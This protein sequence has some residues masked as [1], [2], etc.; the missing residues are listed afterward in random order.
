MLQFLASRRSV[1]THSQHLL[2]AARRQ[3][4]FQ[5]AQ[6]VSVSVFFFNHIFSIGLRDSPVKLETDFAWTVIDKLNLVP[7][8]TTSIQFVLTVSWLIP[9]SV[10]QQAVVPA[11]E[12]RLLGSE[13]FPYLMSAPAPDFFSLFYLSALNNTNAYNNFE[14]ASLVVWAQ[15][16]LL[17]LRCLC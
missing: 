2:G 10:W 12:W 15:A 17:C 9:K 16:K 4:P 1:L 7:D 5:E 11:S 14:I 13:S 6:T 8:C 3:C